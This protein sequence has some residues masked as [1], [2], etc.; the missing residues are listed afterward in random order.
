[1]IDD[2]KCIICGRLIDYV[3]NDEL[4]FPL[5]CEKCKKEYSDDSIFEEIDYDE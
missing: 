5:Y 3:E 2:E 1:M 4:D